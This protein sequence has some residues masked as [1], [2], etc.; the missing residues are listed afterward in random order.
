MRL[1]LAIVALV[2]SG[3]GGDDGALES[4]ATDDFIDMDTPP[5]NC[6]AGPMADPC[7][8]PDTTGAPEGEAC[9]SSAG[10]EGGNACVAPFI[11]GEVGEFTCTSQCIALLDETAWC[12]DAVACCDMGAVCNARG[13]CVVPAGGLDESGSGSGT[14]GEG[15]TDTGSSS[16]GSSSTAGSGSDTETT[17]MR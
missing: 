3:C 4:G 5:G 10:C 15:T 11:D 13:L 16:S 7:P 17:G 14:A 6:S 9:A 12:L 2:A 1:G 8:T